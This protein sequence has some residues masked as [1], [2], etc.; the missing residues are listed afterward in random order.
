MFHPAQLADGDS[1]ARLGQFGMTGFFIFPGSQALSGGLV[2]SG[3][4]LVL[5]DSGLLMGRVLF[6]L[7]RERDGSEQKRQQ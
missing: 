3:D 7:C 1:L 4:R 2:R 5:P 6:C